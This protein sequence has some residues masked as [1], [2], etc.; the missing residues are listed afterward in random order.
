M[1]YLITNDAAKPIYEF[2]ASFTIKP[3]FDG[4]QLLCVVN[5]H[6]SWLPHSPQVKQQVNIF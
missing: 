6:S 5:A 1:A 2:T 4:C 3:S